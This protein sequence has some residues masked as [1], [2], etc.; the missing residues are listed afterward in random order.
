ML[1]C[2]EAGYFDLDE[3]EVAVLEHNGRLSIL[4]RASKRPLAPEDLN[5]D[6][7]MSRL[8]VEL[9][10]DGRIMGE[11]LKRCGRDERWLYKRLSERGNRDVKGIFLC[12]Y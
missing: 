9:I 8:G 7:Q 2:R 6:V 4:P 3:I 12:V 11:N 5:I 10:M 1:L